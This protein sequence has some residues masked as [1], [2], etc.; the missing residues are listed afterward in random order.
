[1][2]ISRLSLLTIDSLVAI[3]VAPADRRPRCPAR[4]TFPRPRDRRRNSRTAADR[5]PRAAVR[6]S[7]LDVEQTLLLPYD[8]RACP[9]VFEAG[10]HGA[11][12][13]PVRR[14]PPP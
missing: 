7:E 2:L 4:T 1:M 8:R 11:G 6:R 9:C 3:E 5:G 14:L 13:V 10:C 12:G